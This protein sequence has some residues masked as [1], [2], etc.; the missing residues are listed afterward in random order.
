QRARG[1]SVDLACPEAEPDASTSLSEQ[2]RAAG[3]TPVLT[4]SRGRGVSLWR[5][6]VDAGRLTELVSQRDIEIV[7]TWHTRDHVLAVRALGDRRR[8]RLTRVVRSYRNADSIRAWPWNRWLFGPGTDALLC[9]SPKSAEINAS[10]R[11]GRPLRGEFGAVDLTRFTPRPRDSNVRKSLDLRE[12][13]FVIGIVARVQRKRRFDLLLAAMQRLAAQQ[14]RARL[15]IIGRGTHLNEV[16]RVTAHKL[17][18]V[19]RVRFAGYLG[20]DYADALRVADIFTFLVPGSD[21]TCRALLE[22]AACGLPAVVTRR[23]SLAEIVIDG[24]TGLVVDEDP[25]SLA[26]AW[27]R[28]LGDPALAAQMGAAARS[29]AERT[30]APAHFA[31][32]VAALYADPSS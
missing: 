4:L 10:I 25:D 27:G 3:V 26:D 15:L 2:A 30:F 19:D 21:G 7:H 28:L 6:R 32:R 12:E 1:C 31:E 18:I 9:V 23:G 5:D 24:E 16:A 11:R 29:R 17:G 22:A 13:D 14:P 8:R 20:A